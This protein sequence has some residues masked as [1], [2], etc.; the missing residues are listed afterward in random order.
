MGTV[1]ASIEP[2]KR[3]LL[4]LFSGCGGLDL[5]FAGGFK[6][7]KPAVNAFVNHDW[8]IKLGRGSFVSLPET[9]FLT[10]FANDIRED[11]KIAWESFFKSK[12]VYHLGSI[13]DFVK[14]HRAGERVFPNN[15]DVVTGGFP[16]QD[17]SVAGKRNGLN[18]NKC[19]NGKLTRHDAPSVENRG[20]LYMWMREVIEITMPKVFVAENVK[21]MANL[22]NVKEIIESD[23]RSIGSDGYLVVDA[24]V[25]HAADYGVP[26]SRERLIFYGFKRSELTQKAAGELSC[27]SICPFY[28]PYPPPSHSFTSKGANLLPHTTLRQALAGLSEPEMA[29]DYS[30]QMYSKA[31]YMGKHCQGQTEINLNGIGPTIRAEHHGNIEY[32]RLPVENG[33]KYIDELEQ[34]LRVRRLTVRECARIQTFPDNYKFVIPSKKGKKGVSASSAYKLIGNAVPPLLGYHIAKRLE[35]NW[36][37][38]FGDDE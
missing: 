32:R 10:V 23:F 11:A 6:V 15:I 8:G 17:F 38:Y 19:H 29:R 9:S 5:G 14:A 21:G 34:G 25:L 2:P 37:L 26:Q 18:S 1:K 16:C 28:D 12:N 20:Q 7:I 33:G 3:R 24:R 36:Q 13:V 35:K 22:G 4:S 31:K 30:Q 27:D